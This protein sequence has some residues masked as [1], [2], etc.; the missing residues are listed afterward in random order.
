MVVEADSLEQWLT[1]WLAGDS[2]WEMRPR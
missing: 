2:L 1:R